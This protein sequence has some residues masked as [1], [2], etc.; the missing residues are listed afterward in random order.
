MEDLI[1]SCPWRH[2]PLVNA[3]SQ[4]SLVGLFCNDYVIAGVRETKTVR[5]GT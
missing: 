5:T 3:P 2:V 4:G 1:E